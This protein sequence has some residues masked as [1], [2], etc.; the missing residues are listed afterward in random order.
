METRVILFTSDH[1]HWWAEDKR[2][3]DRITFSSDGLEWLCTNIDLYLINSSSGDSLRS[4]GNLL[5][6]L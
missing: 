4:L 6:N 2:R 3:L 1:N 5:D